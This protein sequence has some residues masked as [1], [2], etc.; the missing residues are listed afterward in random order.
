MK[1]YGPTL[2]ESLGA[3]ARC[4][5]APRR[6][7]PRLRWARTVTPDSPRRRRQHRRLCR[8]S[9]LQAPGGGLG[10]AGSGRRRCS[11]GCGAGPAAAAGGSGTAAVGQAPPP[12]PARPPPAGLRRR[13]QSAQRRSASA[14]LS[15][16]AR[17]QRGLRRASGRARPWS[18]SLDG[19]R[20]PP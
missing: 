17:G 18:W 14:A 8:A 1:L 12:A 7:R 11:E 4:A 13:L 19:P 9:G 3:A 16:R 6:Q 2:L 15:A 20:P 5:R 10:V